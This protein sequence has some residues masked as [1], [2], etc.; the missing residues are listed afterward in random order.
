MNSSQL[1]MSSSLADSRLPTPVTRLFSSRSLPTSGVKSLSPETITK[2][3]TC[4]R[5]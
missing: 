4:S 5:L 3:S 1:A 2:L